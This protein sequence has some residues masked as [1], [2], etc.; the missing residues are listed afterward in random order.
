[1]ALITW[2][3]I[4]TPQD[5]LLPSAL[6]LYESTF[7]EIVREPLDVLLRG[8][9]LGDTIRP[10]A[11]HLLIAHDEHQRVV[12]L[13]IANYL[14]RANRGFIVYLAVDPAARSQG[15]GAQLI[16]QLELLLQRDAQLAGHAQLDGLVLETEDDSDFERRRRFFHQQGFAQVPNIRYHQPALNP[17]TEVIPLHLFVKGSPG[18]IP[19]LIRAIYEEKYHLI[20]S[21]PLDVLRALEARNR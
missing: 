16:Q 7:E 14:S 19:T 9:Q 3:S 20:N 17:T 11:F 2:H 8:L 10:S 18:D 5:P 12:A 13:T 15:L 4:T 21:I 6:H 1:M